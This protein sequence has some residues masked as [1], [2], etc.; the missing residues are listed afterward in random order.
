[1]GQIPPLPTPTAPPLPSPVGVGI[2]EP[3]VY[4]WMHY[5]WTWGYEIF[6]AF[7][8]GNQ[9]HEDFLCDLNS[10]PHHKTI[11][12]GSQAKDTNYSENQSNSTQ[13]R[14]TH[15]CWPELVLRYAVR[16]WRAKYWL[17]IINMNKYMSNNSKDAIF[18]EKKKTAGCSTA[19]P[20]AFTIYL[21]ARRTQA[22][23]RSHLI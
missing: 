13:G 8:L 6:V 2:F 11:F 23:S 10:S 12:M 9:S 19:K 7:H 1:M 4:G 14:S 15:P 22:S 5:I 3:K 18:S 17:K 16:T 21:E 20:R